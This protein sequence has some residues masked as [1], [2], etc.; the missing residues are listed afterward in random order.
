MTDPLKRFE[1][2]HDEALGVLASLE[3]AAAALDD[4]DPSKAGAA[5]QQ[6]R[7][8]HA[9]LSTAVRAHNDNEERALFAELGDDAPTG[10][11]HAEHVALRTL[12]RDLAVAIDVAE[13][14]RTVPAIARELV[15]LLRAHIEREN[16]VLFPMARE[17]LGR[18]GLARVA[19]RLED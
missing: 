13:P 2:E 14:A 16:A 9:F 12:E 5:L 19:S 1:A 7:E 8:A 4:H 6:V 18:D 10:V 11:F 15:A 3:A 17:R